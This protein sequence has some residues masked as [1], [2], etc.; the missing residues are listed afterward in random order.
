M[1]MELNN[2][3]AIITGAGKGIGKAAAIALA[4]EGVNL[5]LIARTRSDL[6]SIQGEL[7]QAYGVKVFFATADVSIKAEVDA[8]V[9]TLIRRYGKISLKQTS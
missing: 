1:I 3:T 2:K 4:K 5:G 6:E 9:A 7:S 8:A